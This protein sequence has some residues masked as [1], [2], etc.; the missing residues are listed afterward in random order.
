MINNNQVNYNDLWYAPLYTNEELALTIQQFYYVLENT[1]SH[2]WKHGP[3][4][5]YFIDA[6]CLPGNRV[7]CVG[8]DFK[9][10]L[11]L[12]YIQILAS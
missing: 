6:V 1:F 8:L 5:G 11:K 4:N 12:Q 9:M 3:P 2:L 10:L 7:E